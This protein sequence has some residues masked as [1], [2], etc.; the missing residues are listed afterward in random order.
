MT[1]HINEAEV[2]Q[3][4]TMPMAIAAV[5]EVSRKQADGSSH[6]PPAPPLR[7][8]RPWLLPLHGRT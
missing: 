6:R 2:R 7:T 4:L 3:L 5:E 8:S 1:L